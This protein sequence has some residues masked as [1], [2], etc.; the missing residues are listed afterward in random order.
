MRGQQLIDELSALEIEIRKLQFKQL[1]IT[2]E[3]EDQGIAKEMGAYSTASLLRDTVRISPADARRRVADANALFGSTTL[4]GQPIEPQLPVAA[5]ALAEGVISRDHVH[6]VRTT[7]DKLPAEHHAEVEQLLVDEATR[8][9]PV[10]LGKIALRTRAHLQPEQVV[11][12]EQAAR[13]R[14]EFSMIEDID[15]TILLR[16]RLSPECAEVLKAALSPLAKPAGKDDNRSATRR[17][18]DALVELAH[19]I[20]N[21]DTLPQDGGRRPHLAITISYEQLRDQIGLGHGDF[22][23]M[24]TPQTI[25]QIACDAGITPIVLN[26]EGQPLDV[27]RE[28]RL[29]TA[30]IRAALI[31]RDK[32]C[33][34][35]GCDR[36]PEWQYH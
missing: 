24:I 22:G 35:P 23:A 11:L 17:W 6:V 31:A 29:V 18:A 14:M 36:P 9:E 1:E 5:K 12:E 25:R 21:S 26:S 19:R 8:F 28:Q 32:G 20:L 3:I 34:F 30:T 10:T 33:S 16:G 27:G 13:K 15:G 4:T 2:K 7:L